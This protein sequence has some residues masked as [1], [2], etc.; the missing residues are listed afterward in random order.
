MWV[1]DSKERSQ[2]HTR[3]FSSNL[4]HEEPAPESLLTRGM[5]GEMAKAESSLGSVPGFSV[6]GYD[7]VEQDQPGCYWC[8][9]LRKGLW[10]LHF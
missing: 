4:A 1:S 8:L 6:K 9:H 2:G 7:D 10:L 3:K 5:A